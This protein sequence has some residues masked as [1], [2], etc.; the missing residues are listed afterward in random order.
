MNTT[1]MKGGSVTYQR[2]GSGK[3]AGSSI[4]GTFPKVAKPSLEPLKD[5]LED[6]GLDELL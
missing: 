1:L 5:V 3:K 6:R 4:P 2:M